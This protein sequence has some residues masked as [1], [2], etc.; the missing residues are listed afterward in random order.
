MRFDELK[1]RMEAPVF[2][3]GDV[4]RITGKPKAYC[5]LYLLRLERRKKVVRIERGSYCLPGA[6]LYA[7]ASNLILPS[8]VS[9]LSA[10]AFHHLTTQ[11]P[12]QVQVAAARQK[13]GLEFGNARVIFIKLKTKA[14]FGFGK[15]GEAFIAEREKAII[16]CLYQPG[17]APVSEVLYALKQG[18]LDVG[19]LEE[20]AEQLG[21]TVVKK[22]L[23]FLLES[24]GLQTRIK[25]RLNTK[26]DLLNP[27]NPKEG[28]TSGKWRLVLNEVF[29]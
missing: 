11:V 4:A 16:D 14:L 24:A 5:R 9:F 17:R 3:V 20:F 19:R 18:E 2:R 7:V 15:Q 21:S 8:Y 13:K 22:R 6:D 12:V 25:P 1:E 26:M 10:L 27:L 28:K 29:E 23:G